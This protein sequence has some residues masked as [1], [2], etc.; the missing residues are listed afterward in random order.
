[1]DENDYMKISISI[2]I[3]GY[4]QIER[5]MSN[6]FNILYNKNHYIIFSI[7]LLIKN[8][9]NIGINY[10]YLQLYHFL[11][12]FPSSLILFIMDQFLVIFH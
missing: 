2:C 8:N 7:F 11:F 6:I 9:Y 10:T 12:N 3:F 1:M 4:F 5:K